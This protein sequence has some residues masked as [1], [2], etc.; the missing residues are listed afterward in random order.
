MGEVGPLAVGEVALS[1]VDEVEPFAVGEIEPFVMGEVPPPER[2]D[3]VAVTVTVERNV[4]SAARCSVVLFDWFGTKDFACSF[5][6][7]H[8]ADQNDGSTAHTGPSRAFREV[9]LVSAFSDH[10]APDL[11]VAATKRASAGV[12]DLLWRFVAL[13][14]TPKY[15]P[16]SLARS[17]SMPIPSRYRGVF[18]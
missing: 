17:F 18:R 12:P 15:A 13:F 3:W 2:S 16:I 6:V 10:F 8:Y 9:P 14:H 4:V 11:A 7:E 1:A 5:P